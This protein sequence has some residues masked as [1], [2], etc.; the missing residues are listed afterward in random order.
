MVLAALL[1]GLLFG[2]GLAVSGMVNPAKVLAFLDVAGEWDPSLALVMAGA[3]VPAAVAYRW[4]PGWRARPLFDPAYHLPTASA[5]DRPLVAGAVLFGAGWGL[6]GLCPGP[7][8]A[9]LAYGRSES[10]IFFAAMA[11]GIGLS[12]LTAG[13]A[14]RPAATET[15]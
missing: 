1:C 14:G 4:L 9:G 5:V 11:L 6:V 12:R 15:G 3:L 7:A 13:G 10:L 8:I 2:L